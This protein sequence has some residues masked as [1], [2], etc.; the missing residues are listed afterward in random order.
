VVRREDGVS[1]TS[2]PRTAFDASDM[3]EHDDLESLVEHG[4][5]LG[6]F[7]IPTLNAMAMAC[8]H[9]GRRGTGRFAAVLA[10]RPAWRR[11]ARSEH[12]LRLER[13][14]RRRGSPRSYGSIG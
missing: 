8:G 14:L 6:Y 5:D 12:E 1:I 2:P 7:L 10:S 9:Q 4:I 3:L 11:P 13:A